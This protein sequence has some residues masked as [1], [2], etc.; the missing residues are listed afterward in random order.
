MRLSKSKQAPAAPAAVG[1]APAAGND[2]KVAAAGDGALVDAQKDYVIPE[3][4][5][6]F[7]AKTFDLDET[8]KL[9]YFYQQ[10]SS[11]AYLGTSTWGDI[12]R[13]VKYFR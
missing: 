5:K 3:T 1:A 11:H 7:M 6:T 8:D 9:K 13:L 10:Y 4:R 2:A 12:Y